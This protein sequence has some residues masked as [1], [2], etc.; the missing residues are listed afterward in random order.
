MGLEAQK[1]TGWNLKHLG[2]INLRHYHLP[3]FNAM[4]SA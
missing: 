4:L 3:I 1:T 2:K